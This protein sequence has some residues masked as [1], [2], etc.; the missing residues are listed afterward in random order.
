M[1][2]DRPPNGRGDS[3]RFVEALM[4]TQPALAC[5]AKRRPRWRSSV[6]TAAVRPYGE[7]FVS[8]SARAADVTSTTGTTGPNVSSRSIAIPG[9]TPSSTVGSA[10]RLVGN[11]G[12]RRPPPPARRAARR[13][14]PACRG[15]GGGGGG[16]GRGGAPPPPQQTRA[17]PASAPA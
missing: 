11:P 8:S 14:G 15:G 10:Y 4:L 13:G 16:G 12:A 1:L 7:A 5:S 3:H 17:P 2:P 6:K 9:V